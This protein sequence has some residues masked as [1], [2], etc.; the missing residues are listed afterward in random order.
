MVGSRAV[1]CFLSNV[2]L[3]TPVQL[4][5]IESRCLLH[6]SG[7]QREIFRHSDIMGHSHIQRPF[8]FVPRARGDGARNTHVPRKGHGNIASVDVELD[9]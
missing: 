1:A 9:R 2:V 4:F 5:P 7:L 3:P 6:S 8:K